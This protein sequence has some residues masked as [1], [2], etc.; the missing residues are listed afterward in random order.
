MLSVKIKVSLKSDRNYISLHDNFPLMETSRSGLL[1]MRNISD[2]SHRIN[3][4][5]ILVM[6]SENY[7]PKQWWARSLSPLGHNFVVPLIDLLTPV[8]LGFHVK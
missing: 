8:A 4:G 5:K 2:K 3:H 6:A 7:L 1:R